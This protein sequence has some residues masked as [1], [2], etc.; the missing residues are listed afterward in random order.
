MIQNIRKKYQSILR[1]FRL[2]HIIEPSKNSN[3]NT[4]SLNRDFVA[5]ASSEEAVL[6]IFQGEWASHIPGYQ[7][8]GKAALFND[9]RIKWLEK[10]CEGFQGK[11]ILELG[12]MEG[13]HTYMLWKA[14]A[15]TIV[16][17]EGNKRSYLKCLITKELLGYSA[18]FK[19][20]DFSKYLATTN[21]RY[22]F[23]LASGVL[24]HMAEPITLLENISRVTDRIGLWTHYFDE[25]VIANK[26]Y[27]RRRFDISG[28]QMS[29]RGHTITVYR[30]KYRKE[31][32]RDGFVGGIA[33]FSRWLRKEDI[34]SVLESLGFSVVIGEDNKDHKNGP[35]ILLYAQ[36]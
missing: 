35:E 4:L 1:G 7:G 11:S 23:I 29:W 2:R 12:P 10:Q 22:D 24:Y 6:S 26:K 20:G 34:L 9:S 32:G 3:A 14:G 28:E 21:D 18:K 17:I 27:L 25:S 8:G 31:P 5:D 15:A 33:P 13:G 30:Q 19:L 16:A 36:R